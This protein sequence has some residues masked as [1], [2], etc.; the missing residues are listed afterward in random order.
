MRE[1]TK[2]LVQKKCTKYCYQEKIWRGSRAL[3]EKRVPVD[4][5]FYKANAGIKN[6]LQNTSFVIHYTQTL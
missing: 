5:Q 6:K 2:F 1:Q 3:F 4:V